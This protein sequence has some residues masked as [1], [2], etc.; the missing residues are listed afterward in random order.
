AAG[1]KLIFT[2]VGKNVPIC[3]KLTGTFNSTG[4]PTAFLDP[5]QALHGDL[6]FCRDGDFAI[7]ISNSGETQDLL[8]I[9]PFL[10]RLGVAT[11]A[12]TAR[13][14]SS[15]A[16]DCDLLLPFHYDREACPLN[17]APT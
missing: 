11:A 15:L 10:K 16:R 4:V 13:A 9:L 1:H 14:D 3:Q 8:R 17:L 12:M 2:G 6:G 5:N 7:L